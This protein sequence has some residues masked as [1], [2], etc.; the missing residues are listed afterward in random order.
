MRRAL[1]IL[2]V[3]ALLI[4]PACSSNEPAAPALEGTTWNLTSIPSAEIPGDAAANALFQDGTVSGNG[5]C[6]NYSGT[7]ETSGPELTIGPLAS[8]MMACPSP[9]MELESAFLAAMGETASYAI[10]GEEL[11][12]SDVGGAE[13]ARFRVAAGS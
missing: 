13:V 3:A 9:Q 1:L 12:L 2:P 6:N 8:T 7:Y 10:E 11:V 5:G 4:V